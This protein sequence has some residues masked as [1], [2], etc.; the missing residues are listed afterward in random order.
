MAV[1]K[2]R[3]GVEQD[4][5]RGEGAETERCRRR[6]VHYSMATQSTAYHPPFQYKLSV[7]VCVTPK[8]CLCVCVMCS[9]CMI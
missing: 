3:D 1:K 4:K 8:F 2:D 9:A 7:C 6:G 5:K